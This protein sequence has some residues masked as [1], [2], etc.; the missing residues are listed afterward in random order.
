MKRKIYGAKININQNIFHSSY[1]ELIPLIGQA[2]L[3]DTNIELDLKNSKWTLIKTRKI[4]IED[5]TYISGV[6]CKVIKCTSE[7]KYDNAIRNTYT[8]SNLNL[9]HESVFL[10]D[11]YNE[12]IVFEE[13]AN[14][15]R[16]DFIDK[17][18]R[19]CYRIDPTIGEL[20]IKLYPKTI[21]IDNI[22]EDMEKIY[23]AKFNIIPANHRSSKGFLKLD[24][25]LKDENIGELNIVLKNKDGNIKKSENTLFNQCLE[26][27]KKA[28]GN[29]RISSKNKNR[30]DKKDI[31]SDEFV[32]H[33]IIDGEPSEDETNSIFHNLIK[34][35]V[36]DKDGSGTK[37]YKDLSEF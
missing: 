12:I 18:A 10:L 11:S 7:K 21:D 16:H 27:V 20:K 29:F 9:A 15:S 22:V 32:Y 1:E 3:K 24:S 31:N 17:F 13:T 36:I 5:K 35:I 8:A 23:Y 25:V 14:I 19:L 30:E 6:L 2:V 26:M 34:E 37:E 4:I 28:Y 33:K